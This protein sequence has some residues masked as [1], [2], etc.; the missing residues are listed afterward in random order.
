M[1]D[2]WTGH[3]VPAE[4]AV[5]VLSSTIIPDMM[6]NIIAFMSQEN[7]ARFQEEYG[8]VVIS[9][10]EALLT[11]SPTAMT[12]PARLQTAVVPAGG[13]FGIGLGQMYMEMDEVLIGD[14]SMSRGISSIEPG[15]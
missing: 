7:A 8:G 9:F 10:T 11:I 5:Y 3:E 13:A 14:D 15:R 1:K 12:M 6:P 2:W 4:D